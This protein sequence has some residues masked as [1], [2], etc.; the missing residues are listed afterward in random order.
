MTKNQRD[1][2]LETCKQTLDIDK[3]QAIEEDT[4]TVVAYTLLGVE[5]QESS[6]KAFAKKIIT[7]NVPTYWILHSRMEE[8]WNPMHPLAEFQYSKGLHR[9][10]Q[11]KRVAKTVF[12]HYI[13]F[14]TTKNV[15][16]LTHAER[17][18]S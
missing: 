4:R 3:N 1:K 5:V 18:K 15:I 13:N 9:E 17:A 2:E 10:P 11:F 14:L 7:N 12:D 6:S 8:L 16:W